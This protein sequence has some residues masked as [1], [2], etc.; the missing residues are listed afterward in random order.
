ME[1]MER[2]GFEGKDISQ[3]QTS[4]VNKRKNNVKVSKITN[5]IF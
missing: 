1:G 3:R 2:N 5:I 4:E